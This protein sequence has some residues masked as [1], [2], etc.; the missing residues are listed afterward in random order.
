MTPVLIGMLLTT[1]SS[2]FLLDAAAKPNTAHTVSRTVSGT[3]TCPNG[4]IASSA[5]L[6]FGVT[7]YQEF[8][9]IT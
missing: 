3:L 6:V 4:D 7:Q 1:T 5:T 2:L 9:V 8:R